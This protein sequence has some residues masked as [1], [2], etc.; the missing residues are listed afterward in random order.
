[1]SDGSTERGKTEYRNYRHFEAAT[2]ST[3]GKDQIERHALSRGWPVVPAP[4]GGDVEIGAGFRIALH[5][6]VQVVVA[7]AVLRVAGAVAK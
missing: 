2:R 6:D 3:F 7:R 5:V 1:M 4:I